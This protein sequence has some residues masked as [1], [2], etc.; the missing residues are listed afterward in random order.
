[1]KDGPEL[2]TINEIVYA[3]DDKERPACGG[4]LTPLIH[5]LSAHEDNVVLSM[6]TATLQNVIS[7]IEREARYF[8][9]DGKLA[10][11]RIIDV[12]ARSAE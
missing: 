3:W 12:I 2:L 4:D 1:M 8:N 10:A 7:L 6:R 5:Q 9:A 11:R